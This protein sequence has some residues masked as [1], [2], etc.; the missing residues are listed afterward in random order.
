MIH[1]LILI[2]H[3]SC[4][5]R[6]LISSLS[7]N[8]SYYIFALQNFT[9]FLVKLYI[10]FYLALFLCYSGLES[11]FQTHDYVYKIIL[12]NFSII[13]CI[14]RLSLFVHHIYNIYF[15]RKICIS[16][17]FSHLFA[18]GIRGAIQIFLDFF[19]KY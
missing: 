16:S 1:I 8:F 13:I 18:Y 6:S 2:Y 17:R 11:S 3:F 10:F 5:E 9:N 12:F 19:W 4:L 14:P 15:L 7:S